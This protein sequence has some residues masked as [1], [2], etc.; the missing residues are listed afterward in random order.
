L[1]AKKGLK[2]SNGDDKVDL[3]V[4]ISRDLY[5]L[6]RRLAPDLSGESN[7]RGAMGRVV[8][9]ALKQYLYPRASVTTPRNPK[10]SVR[11]VYDQV[12]KVIAEEVGVPW[13]ELKD[14]LETQLE[15]AIAKVR[16]SDPRTIEKWK[17]TF[18]K[19]G[20]IKYIGGTWPKRVVELVA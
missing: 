6:L 14:C 12:K 16:G 20:L 18:L 11:E 4:R 10:L 2:R 7:Y 19:S 9:E 3:H 1:R 15:M 5:D 13:Y 17:K 8:E